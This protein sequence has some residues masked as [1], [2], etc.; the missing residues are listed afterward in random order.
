[1]TH[2]QVGVTIIMTLCLRN[3]I[4]VHFQVIIT[5]GKMSELASESSNVSDLALYMEVK[6][7]QTTLILVK[8]CFV[9]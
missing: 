8:F 4:H 7:K 9:V 6:T 5:T 1:M 2:S 3:S